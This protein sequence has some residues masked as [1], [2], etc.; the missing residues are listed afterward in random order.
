MSDE[1]DLSEAESW[2]RPCG[3]CDA[4]LPMACTCPEDDP[5]TVILRLVQEIKRMRGLAR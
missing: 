2:L 1:L 5:R 4:G 3:S